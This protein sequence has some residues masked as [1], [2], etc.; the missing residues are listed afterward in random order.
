[1]KPELYRR[2]T[3]PAHMS[4]VF[5]PVGTVSEKEVA[6]LGSMGELFIRGGSNSALDQY[7]R[8]NEPDHRAELERV[9]NAW[10]MLI[11]DRHQRV[12]RLGPRF[13]QTLIPENSSLYP[14]LLPPEYRHIDG[15]TAALSGINRELSVDRGWYVDAFSVLDGD[16]SNDR[17]WPRTGSHWT[18]AGTRALTVDLLERIDPQAAAEVREV[19]LTASAKIESDLGNHLFGQGVAEFAP[20]PDPE[21]LTFGRRLTKLDYHDDATPKR[22][23]WRCDDPLIDQRVLIFG[24][25]TLRSHRWRTASPGGSCACSESRSSCGHPKCEMT[26]FVSTCPTS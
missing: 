1:M 6:V 25:H 4:P 8:W 20:A 26:Q 9:T 18:P 12:T 16:A 3:I 7:A 15:P 24:T 19:P 5:L 17:M 23:S 11:R 21:S 22:S 13:F 14:H 2:V 10:T